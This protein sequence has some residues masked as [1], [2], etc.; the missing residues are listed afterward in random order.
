MKSGISTTVHC[1]LPCN[2]FLPLTTEQSPKCNRRWVNWDVQVACVINVNN[3]AQVLDL[4]THS[5]RFFAGS[6]AQ[7]FPPQP[8]SIICYSSVVYANSDTMITV[9]LR[10][11][12]K[13]N[14]MNNEG[15]GVNDW[16][17]H[18]SHNINKGCM[19]ITFRLHKQQTIHH[20]V[21]TFLASCL[22]KEV[23]GTIE[24]QIEHLTEVETCWKIDSQTSFDKKLRSHMIQCLLEGFLWNTY[25]LQMILIDFLI[26]YSCQHCLLPTSRN[27]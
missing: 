3:V 13:P 24:W 4:D 19:L 12:V 16:Q 27:N 11:N 25:S 17:S 14:E 5:A 18:Q 23:T 2:C 10:V 8:A 15:D 21:F 9:Y 7:N 22:W 26:K 6:W 20:S 1:E